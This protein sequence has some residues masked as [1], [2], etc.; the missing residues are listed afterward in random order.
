[1]PLSWWCLH[2][3]TS[4]FFRYAKRLT[5][6]LV[7]RKTKI[8]SCVKS[9]GYYRPVPAS[10]SPG[11]GNQRWTTKQIIA[12]HAIAAQVNMAS[13]SNGNFSTLI[14]MALQAPHRFRNAMSTSA[15][16]PV[17]WDS[18]ASISITPERKDFIGP[19]TDPGPITQLQGIAKGLRIEGQ[20]HVMW[21]MQDTSG[22]IR[23][24]QVPVYLVSRI[25]VRLLSTTSLLQAYP[26]ETITIEAHQLTLSGSQ[27]DQGRG[28]VIARVK[29]DNNLPTSQAYHQSE[30]PKAIEALTGIITTVS[31]SNI[32]LTEAEKELLRWHH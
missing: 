24:I 18:G 29:P 22:G 27:L 21:A 32:N 8:K 6:R 1:M 26:D 23:M 25:K 17:I 2:A 3:T 19:I 28:Q 30:I 14:R 10:G 11:I 4:Y 15:A 7:L 12:A 31:Q 9:K 16:F 20:G 5:D 13:I